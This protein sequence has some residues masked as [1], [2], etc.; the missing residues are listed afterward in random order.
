MLL[1]NVTQHIFEALPGE[2]YFIVGP[3]KKSFLCVS[4]VVLPNFVDSSHVDHMNT[5]KRS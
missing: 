4:P 5:V 2:Y 3:D 1:N